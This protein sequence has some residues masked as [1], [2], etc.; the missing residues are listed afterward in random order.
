MLGEKK[1]PLQLYAQTKS[2]KKKIGC[3]PVI[4]SGTGRENFAA[5]KWGER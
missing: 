2:E 4:V 3:L 1:M 5:G